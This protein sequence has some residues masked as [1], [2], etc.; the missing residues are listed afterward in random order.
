M[1]GI[2]NET[3]LI[4]SNYS[5]SV[6]NKSTNNDNRNY[7]YTN[8]SYVALFFLL[9]SIAIHIAI[10][11]AVYSRRVLNQPNYH[12][13]VNVAFSNIMLALSIIVSTLMVLI[14]PR[15]TV[16]PFIYTLLCKIFVIFPLYWSY[17]ALILV[18]ILASVERY[19]IVI[20]STHQLTKHKI[21]NYSILIWTISLFASFP[22]VLTADS[23]QSTCISFNQL[24]SFLN[25]Y[26]IVFITMFYFIP[27]LFLIIIYTLIFYRH[28]RYS[29]VLTDVNESVDDRYIV[30]RSIITWLIITILCIV[31]TFPW[32]LTLLL[33]VII[34]QNEVQILQNQN[35]SSYISFLLLLAK[36]L[37]PANVFYSPIVYCIFNPHFRSLFLSCFRYSRR[38]SQRSFQLSTIA[39]TFASH[40]QLPGVHSMV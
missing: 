8:N 23:I 7:F 32:I 25:I 22:F 13:M 3:I 16:V 18:L 37:S 40:D 28:F 36:A 34:G 26:Y 31:L 11:Q 20:R 1:D 10:I 27:N 39:D 29:T 6:T 38:S 15:A 14:G 5:L 2:R 12:V 35:I 30:T 17:V 4:D 21:K 19:K 33:S 9:L 24:T